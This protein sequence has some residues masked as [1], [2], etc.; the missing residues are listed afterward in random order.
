MLRNTIRNQ[1]IATLTNCTQIEVL[2]VSFGVLHKINDRLE[3]ILKIFSSGSDFYPLFRLLR[4]EVRGSVYLNRFQKESFYFFLD[5]R[6]D[7]AVLV[8]D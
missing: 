4:S 6:G 8:G 7:A 5:R 1:A 3:R 2:G